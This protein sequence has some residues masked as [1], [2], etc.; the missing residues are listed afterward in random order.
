[1]L[2]SSNTLHIEDLCNEDPPYFSNANWTTQVN[3]SPGIWLCRWNR[4]KRTTA[5]GKF[6]MKIIV[7][8]ALLYTLLQTIKTQEYSQ[9]YELFS[10]HYPLIFMN[11]KQDNMLWMHITIS[12]VRQ[13][14]VKEIRERNIEHEIDN[15]ID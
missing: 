11:R 14:V 8:S 5:F 7:F 6:Q 3:C 13:H 1:M 12:I 4:S 10:S 9:R 15:L 2:M